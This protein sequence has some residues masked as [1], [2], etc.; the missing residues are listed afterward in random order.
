MSVFDYIFLQEI[1]VFAFDYPI[2]SVS[3]LE[4]WPKNK[5]WPSL[6]HVVFHDTKMQKDPR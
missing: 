1:S 2:L 5:Q 4:Y 3:K 6:D